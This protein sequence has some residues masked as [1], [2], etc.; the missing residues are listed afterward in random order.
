MKIYYNDNYTNSNTDFPTTKKSAAVAQQIVDQRDPNLLIVDP[1]DFTEQTE[2]IIATIHDA[3]YIQALKTGTPSDLATSQG[4]D[5]DPNIWNMAL[6][7][8]TGIVAAVS[9]A[10]VNGQSGGSLSSGLHHA[11]ADHGSGFCTI[12][13]LA[14]GVV[15]AWRLGAKNVAVLDLDAHNGGGTN[16]IVGGLITHIDISTNGFDAYTPDAGSVRK[17]V[18]HEDEYLPTIKA[19]LDQYSG[20]DFD[21]VIYN[22][23][24][25][26]RNDGFSQETLRQ[27]EQLVFDWLTKTG[28]PFVFTLAGGYTWNGI[29]INEIENLHVFTAQCAAL[30]EQ[31][32]N[33]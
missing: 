32:V 14:V 26:P 10:I 15:A 18:H 16:D 11:K 5:W 24:M 19:A 28:T 9:D 2:G 22:A 3:D 1:V 27:R 31:T 25:D 33:L 29:S 21:L 8:S 4:F 12:N 7:H 30:A 6:A 13:G 23:G 17:T 20:H